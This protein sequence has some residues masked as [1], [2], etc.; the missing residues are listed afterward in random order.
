M[1]GSG[2]SWAT[3]QSAPRSRQI[4]TPAPHHS[5]SYRPD[6]LPA[7]LPT[8]SKHWR[9]S[10][11]THAKWTETSKLLDQQAGNGYEN[12]SPHWNGSVTRALTFSMIVTTH[13][14]PVTQE[15][16]SLHECLFQKSSWKLNS[17]KWS[18]CQPTVTKLKALIATEIISNSSKTGKKNIGIHC[19]VATKVVH[20]I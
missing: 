5:V 11:R 6:A 15:C 1:S 7:A 19:S 8:A 18:K 17:A 13:V 2:I 20:K 3:C 4:T 16:G 14:R 9:Q 12:W 10:M